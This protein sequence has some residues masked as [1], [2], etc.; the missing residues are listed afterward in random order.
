MLS[1]YSKPLLNKQDQD[2]DYSKHDEFDVVVDGVAVT[3]VQVVGAAGLV[4][5]QRQSEELR[6]NLKRKVAEPG[7]ASE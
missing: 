7:S 3:G 4:L 6:R 5:S 2:H 1:N